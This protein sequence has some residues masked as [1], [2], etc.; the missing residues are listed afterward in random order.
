MSVSS[1]R[2]FF[3]VSLLAVALGLAS[4]HAERIGLYED[5]DLM[6][7]LDV[8]NF[9]DKVVLGNTSYVVEF[10]NAFCGHCMRFAAP[11]KEFGLEVYGKND[12]YNVLIIV[13]YV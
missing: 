2:R 7:I 10:Y 13:T 5:T 11:Y 4:I 1:G 6:E 3:A 9:N 12:F 8:N